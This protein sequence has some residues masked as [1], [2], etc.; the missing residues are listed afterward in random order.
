M[1]ISKSVKRVSC[2]CTDKLHSKF[3]SNRIQQL[4]VSLTVNCLNFFSNTIAHFPL[5]P[6]FT[7]SV[8][9]TQKY[10]PA[11]LT[12]ICGWRVQTEQ[13]QFEFWPAMIEENLNSAIT[14]IIQTFIVSIP[15]AKL[16]SVSRKLFSINTPQNVTR[17]PFTSFGIPCITIIDR[18]RKVS[19]RSKY[20]R[21]A[22][23]NNRM[24]VV[25]SRHKFVLLFPLLRVHRCQH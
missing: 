12:H 3:V 8:S 4:Q 21:K 23:C 22:K 25:Q 1:Q 20:L 14:L 10:L 16:Q 19:R 15:D 11:I 5:F 9:I 7:R 18:T 13:Q 6:S 24:F 2:V 17:N